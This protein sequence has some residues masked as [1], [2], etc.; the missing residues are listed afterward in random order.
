MHTLVLIDRAKAGDQFVS[1]KVFDGSRSRTPTQI[2]A[3]IGAVRQPGAA[4][5]PPS[6]AAE[7][8]TVKSP[9]LDKPSWRVRLAFFPPAAEEGAE[10]PDY[11]LGM[12][13]LNNGVS[14]DMNLDYGDYVIKARLDEI[15]P[16][17]KPA[18]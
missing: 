12:R 3:V 9:L 2:T 14:R 5:A 16:L 6:D 8:E 11:E 10:T 17:T 13:L 7:G 15:E 4:A 1:R 18:C